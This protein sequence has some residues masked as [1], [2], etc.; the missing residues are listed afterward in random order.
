VLAQQRCLMMSG[1][2]VL[3]AERCTPKQM[4]TPLLLFAWQ[5]AARQQQ[6]RRCIIRHHY[7]LLVAREAQS[8]PA[9]CA[10]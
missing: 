6:L 5:A 10:L 7:L 3:R 9:N 1:K 2:R 4:P 8:C